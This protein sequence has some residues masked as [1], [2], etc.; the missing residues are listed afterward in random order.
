MKTIKN[1]LYI[2]AGII[3]LAGCTHS[4]YKKT[5]GGV[6]YQVIPGK[7]KEKVKIGDFIKVQ[8]T[9]KIKDSVYF[10]TGGKMA[11]Y[12]HV[13]PNPNPYDINEIWPSLNVGDSII[14][15]QLM[16]TFILRSP[17]SV[18]PQFKKGDK[19][20][21]YAKVVGVFANDSLARLDD[22]K[23]KKD[24]LDAEIK[25]LEAYLASKNITAQKTPSG[26][27]VQVI[28][29]GEGNLIDSGKYVTVYYTGTSFSGKKFDSNTDT[30]F[31]HTDPLPF[32][33]GTGGM[34]KG[35]DEAAKFLRKGGVA[36]VFIPSMLG[37]AGNPPPG[38][39][40]KPYEHLIFDMEIKDV[41]DKAPE[42]PVMRR[43][44]QPNVEKVDAPQP[45]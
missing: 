27:F 2:M 42:N 13:A 29:P 36:K 40:L 23:G 24:L 11:I 32:V 3:I 25:E 21:T 22:E 6:A 41:L 45:K 9:Q 10:T 17:Q 30:S 35:F 39:P 4:S 33:V 8:L 26:S 34:I 37:Y 16:D 28:K 15:T 31:H 14:A 38:L 1:W 7:G 43:P 19:I 12:L 18:P 44:T 20:M 5:P